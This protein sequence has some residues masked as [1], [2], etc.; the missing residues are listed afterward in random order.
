MKFN[1]IT[2]CTLAILSIS[3]LA[4]C[5]STSNFFRN[6]DFDY[7]R[8]PVEQN[9][10]LEVPKSVSTDPNIHLALVIPEGQTSFT[11]NQLSQAQNAML[12]P[13]FASN[14]DVSAVEQK[15]LYV[16]TTKLNYD[17]DNQA[18]LV[19]YEPH[20]VTWMIVESA[21]KDK[22]PNVTLEKT[23]KD[24]NR[25]VVKDKASG[26][27][28]YVFI[29]QV[30]NEF[31]R[32][33]LSL[34]NMDEKPAVTKEASSIVEQIQK[35]IEGQK[36]TEETLVNA[37]FGFINSENGLKFQLYTKDKV[38]SVVFVGDE[39]L[40][41]KTLESALK[42]AGYKY[43]AYDA[44]EQTILF[45]DNK[46]QSYLLYLYPYTQNGSIFSD[47]SNWRNF[48][49]EEQKQLRVSLFDTKQVLIPV[50]KAKPILSAIASHIP[51]K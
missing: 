40:A 3:T 44:K 46:D 5:A 45:E 28:Y 8:Q 10:P 21:L 25:F 29:A 27:S 12:P 9:K 47:M 22:L 51:L 39:A 23:D 37:Q 48:F 49:R 33:E 24:N 36:V 41:R 6:R 17:K 13:N 43:V 50:D 7:A 20:A 2:A 26:E 15:Q 42:A 32:A 16:V 19:I 30:K 31:R 4:G 14:Y 35:S 1:K 18:K 34:F 38:V 11:K